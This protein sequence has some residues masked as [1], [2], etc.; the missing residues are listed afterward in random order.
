MFSAQSQTERIYDYKRFANRIG[1]S[2]SFGMSDDDIRNVLHVEK[3]F[4][5]LKEIYPDTIFRYDTSKRGY[6]KK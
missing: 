6:S 5:E 1:A 4:K 3:V 2:I